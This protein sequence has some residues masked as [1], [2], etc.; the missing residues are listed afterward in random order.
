MRLVFFHELINEAHVAN[1]IE[2]LGVIC[3]LFRHIDS[4]PTD[5]QENAPAN[6]TSAR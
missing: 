2:N 4:G 6:T 3:D 1:G 5:N